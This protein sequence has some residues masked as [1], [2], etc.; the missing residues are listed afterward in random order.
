[1][2]ADLGAVDYFEGGDEALCEERISAAK[3]VR[4]R[5]DGEVARLTI[6]AM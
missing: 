6:P 5:C 4:S 2:N 1:V 3:T